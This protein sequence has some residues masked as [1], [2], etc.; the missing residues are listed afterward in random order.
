M[1]SNQYG[2]VFRNYTNPGQWGRDAVETN[3]LLNHKFQV[4]HLSCLVL[5]SLLVC[6]LPYALH[7]FLSSVARPHLKLCPLAAVSYLHIYALSCM[8]NR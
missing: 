2:Q 4:R 1:Q 8:E 3:Y 6:Q 7:R 5:A